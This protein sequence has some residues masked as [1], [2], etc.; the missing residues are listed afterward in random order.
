MNTEIERKFLV[1]DSSWRKS[2]LEQFSCTQGYISQ[3]RGI[4]VRV[5]RL[6]ERGFLT[7][8]G[9][10]KNITRSEFEYEIPV[11]DA[12]YMLKNFCG[13]RIISKTRFIVKNEGMHW[14]VDEFSDLNQGLILAE[15][16]LQSET[17]NFKR[18]IWLGEEV[19]EDYRYF[20]LY[21]SENPFSKW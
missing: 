19:S 12:E 20:N 10:S 3:D 6:G 14:E 1:R 18:P 4:T 13:T 11:E 17:Q 2:V 15:I 9:P 5:R 21:L 8:K 7:V 16:E